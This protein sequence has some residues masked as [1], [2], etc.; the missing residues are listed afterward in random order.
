VPIRVVPNPHNEAY[1]RAKGERLGHMLHHQG[2]PLDE[3]LLHAEHE[4]DRDRGRH[5]EPG[6]AGTRP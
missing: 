1:L 4:Q 2:L 6:P 3:E 5:D